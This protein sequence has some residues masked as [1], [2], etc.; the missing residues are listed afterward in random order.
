MACTLLLGCTPH[1]ATGRPVRRCGPGFR[2]TAHGHVSAV[3]NA[4]GLRPGVQSERMVPAHL[5]T[6]HYLPP[7]AGYCPHIAATCD[8]IYRITLRRRATPALAY[9][10]S[11][12]LIAGDSSRS[13]ISPI[14]RGAGVRPSRRPDDDCVSTGRCSSRS[15]RR[16]RQAHH[17]YQ[18]AAVPG[19]DQP[20]RLVRGKGPRAAQ[21]SQIDG[22]DKVGRQRADDAVPAAATAIARRSPPARQSWVSAAALPMNVKGAAGR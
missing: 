10:P 18:V 12:R 7:L 5:D 16:D 2:G 22:A 20:V 19:L 8:S 21:Q 3:P 6:A 11:I 14:S 4:K 1:R 9:A 13:K 17:A 15:P